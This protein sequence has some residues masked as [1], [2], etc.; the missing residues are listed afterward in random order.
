MAKIKISFWVEY[1]PD[2]SD[3]DLDGEQTVKACFDSCDRKYF[4][5]YLDDVVANESLNDLKI[6]LEES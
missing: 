6:E 4:E 2:P 3:Y 1:N 5:Q